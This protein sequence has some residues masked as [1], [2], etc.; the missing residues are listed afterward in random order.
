MADFSMAEH[1]TGL[2]HHIL[3]NNISILAKKSRHKGQFMGKVTKIKLNPNN[4]SRGD[5]FSLSRSWRPLIHS[6]KERKILSKSKPVT[7]S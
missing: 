3:L 5:R 4:I 6:L 2:G 1:S 7:S